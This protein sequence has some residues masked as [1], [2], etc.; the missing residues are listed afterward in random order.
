MSARQNASSVGSL[1][2]I[3]RL[4]ECVTAIYAQKGFVVSALYAVFYQYEGLLVE[5]GQIIQQLIGHA[6]GA[7]A[8]DDTYDIWH[9]ECL[10]VEQLE[11]SEWG[12]GVGERLEI[13]QIF[14][15]GIFVGEESFA[16]FEL[17]SH[18]VST[19]TVGR[20]KSS[21]VAIDATTCRN[22]A[23]AIGTTKSCIDRNLLHTIEET[24]KGQLVFTSHNLRP[25]EVL[26][27]KAFFCDGNP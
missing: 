10:F 2:G 24:G 22:P 16:L 1:D 15:I 18:R 12:I 7:C 23:V 27:K 13:S 19:L 20:V 4:L 14:H 17:L 9:A 6:I 21:V 3:A 26:D 11:L 8:D 25:L 5:F